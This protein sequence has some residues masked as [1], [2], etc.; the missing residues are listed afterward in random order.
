MFVPLDWLYQY[1]LMLPEIG[2]SD[3]QTYIMAVKGLIPTF[4]THLSFIHTE[5]LLHDF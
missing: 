1:Y 3:D 2:Y 5:Y 4:C